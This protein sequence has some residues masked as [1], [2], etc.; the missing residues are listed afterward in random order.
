[1]GGSDKQSKKR[2]KKNSEDTTDNEQLLDK[3]ASDSLPISEVIGQAERV[4]TIWGQR[5]RQNI[6]PSKYPNS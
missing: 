2:K 6:Y 3:S 4:R 1:M 5:H